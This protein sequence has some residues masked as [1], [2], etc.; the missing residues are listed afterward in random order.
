[1]HGSYCSTLHDRIKLLFSVSIHLK[2]RSVLS[3]CFLW[4]RWKQFACALR[5]T[6]VNSR[7]CLSTV[8]QL[9]RKR[10]LA[11]LGRSGGGSSGTG[12]SIAAVSGWFKWDLI[13]PCAEHASSW[14]VR[15]FGSQ[16]TKCDK[17]ALL[18]LRTKWQTPFHGHAEFKAWKKIKRR[19]FY[20][21]L[22]ENW[23]IWAQR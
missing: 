17:G 7:S 12:L 14:H 9:W 21:A 10:S 15:T 11:V 22:K 8:Y 18:Y 4:F 1:M 20:Y 13:R 23:F 16:E 3:L 2:L 19:L 6:W 5:L